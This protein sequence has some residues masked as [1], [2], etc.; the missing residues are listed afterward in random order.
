MPGSLQ[1]RHLEMTL[2]G[3]TMVTHGDGEFEGYTL[4]VSA[5]WDPAP[6]TGG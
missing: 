3:R 6:D 2:E 4:S 5:L 1:T